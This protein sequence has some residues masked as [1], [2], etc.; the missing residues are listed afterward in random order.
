MVRLFLSNPILKY[1]KFSF[2]WQVAA[3]TYNLHFYRF[4]VFRYRFRTNLL[5]GDNCFCFAMELYL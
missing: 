4:Q 2:S 3:L 1:K 5:N